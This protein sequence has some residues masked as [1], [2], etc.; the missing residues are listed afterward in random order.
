MRH[1]MLDL[2]VLA[3]VFKAAPEAD[4]RALVLEAPYRHGRRAQFLYEA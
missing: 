4:I 3:R 2:L 1:E